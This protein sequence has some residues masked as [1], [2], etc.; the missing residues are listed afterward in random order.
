MVPPSRSNK[1]VNCRRLFMADIFRGPLAI[2]RQYLQL[3]L[4]RYRRRQK[5]NLTVAS[6]EFQLP[7]NRDRFSVSAQ[8]TAEIRS[9]GQLQI[10]SYA[11]F[12]LEHRNALLDRRQKQSFGA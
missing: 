5:A 8:R 11:K 2:E 3:P 4:D 12:T 1:F 6:L 9:G 10:L 7:C